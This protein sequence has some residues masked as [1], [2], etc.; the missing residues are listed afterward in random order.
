[1]MADGSVRHIYDDVDDE[2]FKAL[3]TIHGGEN[4]DVSAAGESAEDWNSLPMVKSENE[5]E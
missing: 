2:V 1:M 3:C 4:V 5:E